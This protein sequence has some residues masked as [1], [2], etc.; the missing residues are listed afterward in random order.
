MPAPNTNI[1]LIGM[2]GAGKSTIGVILAKN[3]SRD[4]VDTDLLIQNSEKR[5]LQNILDNDGYLV[6][7]KIEED[8]LLSLN[9][10]STVIATGGSAIY[11]DKA[12][13]HLK[14]TSTLVFLDV[15]LPTLEARVGDF[16][17]RGIAKDKRQN[18]ADLFE[19][20]SA[21]YSTYAD[22]R[23][24]CTAQ[25]QEQICA[26]IIQAIRFAT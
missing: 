13:A 20:R 12:M 23:I 19:E 7:R 24:N 5:T 26:N 6:L 18:F 4:F 8:I 16:S 14:K 3:S 15:N 2:P 9:T 25:S 21:L 1:V 10:Q 17:E 22:I 11:S